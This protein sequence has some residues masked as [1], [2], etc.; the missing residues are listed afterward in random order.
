VCSSSSE[1]LLISHVPAHR[2]LIVR[3]LK[4]L[5]DIISYTSVHY[6]LDTSKSWRFV[7]PDEKLPLEECTPDPL[8]PGVE[9]LSELYF[10]A[11]PDY[12]GRF[13]VPV[14]WDKQSE[15]IVNNESSEIIR[16]L[17]TEFDSFVPEKYRHVD[18]YPESLRPEID[19]ANGWMYDN[20]NNGV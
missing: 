17:Y 2:A 5:E 4:G 3:K 16:M 6:T 20:I 13:T 11:S 14:L 12:T 19:L 8:H 18:L 10:K 15:T 9:W 7:K 1:E